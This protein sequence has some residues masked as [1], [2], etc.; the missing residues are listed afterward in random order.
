M[1]S[2]TLKLE[3]DLGEI[4]IKNVIEYVFAKHY[5]Y[6]SSKENVNRIDRK[7]IHKAYR[8]LSSSK[9]VPINMKKFK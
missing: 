7:A 1:T 4:E 9:W 2:Y 6:Y 3:T 8:L 5:F